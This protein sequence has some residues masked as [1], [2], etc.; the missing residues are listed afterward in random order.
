MLWPF[1]VF[2]GFS[3][4]ARDIVYPLIINRCFGERYMAEIYGALML[5]LPS[6]ALGALL[7]AQVH[8]RQ[9]SYELAFLLFAGL[10]VLTLAGL[11]FVRDE[12][13]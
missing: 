5:A 11:L 2:Y 8:D 7:A 12:R 9:G 6:G 4:A 3:T 1:V 13:S 10:N